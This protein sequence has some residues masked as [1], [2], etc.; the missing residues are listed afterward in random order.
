[1]S[2][3]KKL[4]LIKNILKNVTSI[5]NLKSEEVKRSIQ[6]LIKIK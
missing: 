2:Y 5:S 1:M 3:N 4:I 6:K